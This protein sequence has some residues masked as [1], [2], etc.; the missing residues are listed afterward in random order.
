MLA[1]LENRRSRLLA[2]AV[3]LCLMSLTLDSWQRAARE[4]GSHT[5]LDSTVC[6]AAT[7]LQGLLA[8]GA[9][10][11]A[12]TA[13]RLESARRLAKD[14]A[15]LRGQVAE[16]QARLI[17]LEE[18]QGRRARVR[19]LRVAT[20]ALAP[21]AP[22][23]GVIGW[24]EEGW[25]SCLTLDRGERAGLRP[26]D[27]ALAKSGLVG[28]IYAVSAT[29]ARVL[30]ITDPASGVAALVKRSR[31]TGVV[32]GVGG[33]GCELRYLGPEADV[34]AGDLVLT[35]GAGGIFPKGL[36]IGT[37]ERVT[38][39]PGLPGRVASVR[40]AVELRKVEEVAILR[41]R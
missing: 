34:R 26:R 28:Q 24:G 8:A 41:A 14:N 10:G 39:A 35:S 3:T 37:V 4:A 12:R 11:Y 19:E 9:D 17:A 2:L 13:A 16:L 23:A 1:H 29:S 32:K 31:E 38:R 27:I 33:G 6:A 20:S 25:T 18:E 36:L 15:A 7:P 21:R 30:P 40:P 22:I 5:W